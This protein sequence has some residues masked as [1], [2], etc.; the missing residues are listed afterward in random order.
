VPAARLY[1]HKQYVILP[2]GG[3]RTLTR[4]GSLHV[5]ISPG[6][7]RPK[8]RQTRPLGLSR[9]RPTADDLLGVSPVARAKRR[10]VKFGLNY[11]FVIHATFNGAGIT[12]PGYLIYQT[13]GLC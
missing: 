9:F 13:R 11:P 12:F 10:L 1:H 6:T 2:I 4:H 7:Y 5:T 3:D 8:N